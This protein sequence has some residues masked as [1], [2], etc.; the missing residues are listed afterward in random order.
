MDEDLLRDLTAYKSYKDKGV[1]MASRSLIQ[2]FRN[3]KP[4]MLHRKDR[5]RVCV[6]GGEGMNTA[7]VCVCVRRC[8][9][10]LSIIGLHA[11][12]A[13]IHYDAICIIKIMYV[14]N[15]KPQLFL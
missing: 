5:V 9:G 7:C 8:L 11:D 4:D 12:N 10:D 1:M 2:L 14:T 6:C 3:I 13:D 15:F